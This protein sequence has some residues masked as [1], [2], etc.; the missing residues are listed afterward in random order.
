MDSLII[1][2]TKV[3]CCGKKKYAKF[4]KKKIDNF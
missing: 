3:T 4:V 1:R 2:E